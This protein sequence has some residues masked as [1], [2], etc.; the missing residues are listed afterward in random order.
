MLLRKT[1]ELAIL[2]GAMLALV[3]QHSSFFIT[4]TASALATRLLVLHRGG[5]LRS[6]RCCDLFG[7]LF[8]FGQG[9]LYF[10]YG[11]FYDFCQL[12]FFSG[13]EEGYL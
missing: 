3:S 6:F 8:R 11:F 7:V 1:M 10:L 4:F 13:L 12:F 2:M 9:D 5:A